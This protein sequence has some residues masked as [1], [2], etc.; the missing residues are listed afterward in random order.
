MKPAIFSY[1]RPGSWSEAVELV[2]A[3]ARPGAGTQSLGPLLNLRLAQPK[4]IADLR[5]LPDYAGVTV[6]GSVLRIGAGTTHASIEDGAVPGRAGE[7]M[8]GIARRIAYR[9][10]RNLGT[11]GGSVALADPSA[12]WP[13]CLM[14]LGAQAVIAGP[15]GT[16]REE[17][18]TLIQGPYQTSLMPGEIIV[19]F[20]IAQH[21][22]AR[23]GVSKVSRKSGAFADSIA[24]FIDTTSDGPARLALTG[25]TSHARILPRVGQYA[26]SSRVLN[27]DELRATV[28]E[29][30]AEIDPAA[31]AYQLRCHVATVSR[32][33]AE[34]R[35]T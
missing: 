15:D 1:A 2:K 24:V 13:A 33:I 29:D 3:G 26:E 5:H 11:I 6:A 8:A 20:E 25:T 21:K 30:L 10:V 22:S 35:A 34:A 17:V 27:P 23:W 32:A 16:R 9:A 4:T 18:E 12:D 31:D 14:A 19:G 7:I 28:R